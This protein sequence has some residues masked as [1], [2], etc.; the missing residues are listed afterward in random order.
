MKH[1]ISLA[2]TA[3][4]SQR[5]GTPAIALLAMLLA[6]S[7]HADGLRLNDLPYPSQW[8]A[9]LQLS[10]VDNGADG[11]EAPRDNG[12][13]LLGAN[14]LGDYYLTGSGLTGVR[15]GLRATGGLWVGPRSMT[16]GNAGLALDASPGPLAMGA[17]SISLGYPG[18]DP[19]DPSQSASYLGI[20]YTGHSMHTG[21]SFS[22][23]LGLLTN[24]NLAALR[25]G[26]GSGVRLDDSARFSPVLQLGLSY[27]Y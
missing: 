4:Q 24:M 18:T 15:G 10:G 20:G 2:R 12:S 3:R 6:A 13:R 26:Y 5:G 25:L 8:Q 22:A 11:L 16:L 19:F 1:V 14:L 17:R 9:R 7:A 21:V 23:D 27:S